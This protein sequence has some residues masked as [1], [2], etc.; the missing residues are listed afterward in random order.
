MSPVLF[1]VVSYVDSS[2]LQDGLSIPLYALGEWILSAISG[3]SQSGPDLECSMLAQ[4]TT[5]LDAPSDSDED[6]LEHGSP[7][8]DENPSRALE[9]QLK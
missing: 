3:R 5:T 9:T 7:E 6:T 2:V 4:R 8:V 1:F